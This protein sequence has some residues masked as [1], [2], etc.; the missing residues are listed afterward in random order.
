[1]VVD[2]NR[3]GGR[4][5]RADLDLLGGLPG[6]PVVGRVAGSRIERGRAAL[7]HLRRTGDARGRVEI[8]RHRVGLRNP[9]VMRELRFLRESARRRQELRLMPV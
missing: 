9:L 3:V 1:M 4:L 5:L 6:G 8:Q 7:A 2:V